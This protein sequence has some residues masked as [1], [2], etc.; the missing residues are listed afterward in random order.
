VGR[1]LLSKKRPTPLPIERAQE[2]RPNGYAAMGPPRAPQGQ[3][4]QR[5]R[6]GV[7]YTYRP[8]GLTPPQHQGT[9]HIHSGFQGANARTASIGGLMKNRLRHLNLARLRAD[10]ELSESGRFWELPLLRLSSEPSLG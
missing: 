3:A 2:P 8:S 5:T 9:L 10:H 4:T 1:A 6:A 7:T